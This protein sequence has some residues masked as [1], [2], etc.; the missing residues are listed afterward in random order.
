MEASEKNQEIIN[1]LNEV[2]TAELTAINQYFLHAELCQHWGYER[3]YKTVRG[4]S[5]DEMKHAEQLME[6]ILYLDGL[7]N[8]Q[9]LGKVNVGESVPEQFELDFALEKEA[10]ERL[11]RGIELCRDTS[12]NGTRALLEQILASEEEHIDWL[13]TQQDLIAQIGKENYLSQQMLPA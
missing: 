3:L 5:I 1:L 9:R 12:D 6:R 2:L 11:N 7:P 10:I 13:E 8:V 4:H